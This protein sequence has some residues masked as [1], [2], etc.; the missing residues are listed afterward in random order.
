MLF[1]NLKIII[2]IFLFK[3]LFYIISNKIFLK[4]FYNIIFCFFKL[5]IKIK[6]IMK[7]RL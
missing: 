6:E 3:K 5:I 7:I 2:I 4:K 1:K